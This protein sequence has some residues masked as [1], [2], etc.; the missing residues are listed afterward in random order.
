MTT[1]EADEVELA[2]HEVEAGALEL[3]DEKRPFPSFLTMA[4]RQMTS[5]LG[6][7]P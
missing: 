2:V 6:S 7:T 3:V 5:S 1:I 4:D